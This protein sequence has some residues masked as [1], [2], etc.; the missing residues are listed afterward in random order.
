MPGFG[1]CDWFVS[2]VQIINTVDRRNPANQLR[3]VGYPIICKVLYIQGGAG[4]L[5]STACWLHIGYV[6]LCGSF[7][8]CFAHATHALTRLSV[9]SIGMGLAMMVSRRN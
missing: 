6:T 7:F 1:G 5:P 2:L 8:Q 9:V 4:V 3:L